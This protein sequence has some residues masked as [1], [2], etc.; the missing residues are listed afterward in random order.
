MAT[1]EQSVD[2]VSCF[3]SGLIKENSSAMW[4][5]VKVEWARECVHRSARLGSCQLS[6][7]QQHVSETVGTKTVSCRERKLSEP[8]PGLPLLHILSGYQRNVS[9]LLFAFV[10]IKHVSII[11][12]TRLWRVQS[13]RDLEQEFVV[14]VSAHLYFMTDLTWNWCNRQLCPFQSEPSMAPASHSMLWSWHSFG[15]KPHP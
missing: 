14:S 9:V 3:L 6:K 12:W 15:I 4:A 11:R 8:T 10:R 2:P 7:A 1:R 5:R 13:C